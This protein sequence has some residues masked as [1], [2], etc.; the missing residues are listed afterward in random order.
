MNWS[1][2]FKHWFG[3]LLI[4][5]IIFQI[6]TPFS[7]HIS[8]LVFSFFEAYPLF[9]LFGLLFSIPTYILYG[10]IYY[11]LARKDANPNY[12]KAILI[13]FS[14]L[15]VIATT[16]IMDGSMMQDITLPYLIS[17]IIAGLL[18]KLNFRKI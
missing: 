5:P 6:T 13:L 1:Y 10:C 9:L 16:L 11:Y 3:T 15:G 8:H 17:S 14:V 2:L 18:F 7:S 4:G 12:A